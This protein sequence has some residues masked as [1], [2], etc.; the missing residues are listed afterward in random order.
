MPYI[1][2]NTCGVGVKNPYNSFLCAVKPKAHI[3]FAVPADCQAIYE[4]ICELALYEKAADEVDIDVQDLNGAIFGNK[5]ILEVLVAELDGKVEGAAMFFEKYSTW[6]GKG[7]HLEDLVVR[8]NLRGQGIGAALFEALMHISAERGYARMD[9]QVLDW[10]EPAI[11]FYKK[12][13]AEIL[14]EWLNGRFTREALFEWTN[15]K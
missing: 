2:A 12:Y 9:W 7:V 10:N 14:E 1:I 3:R 13:G 5:P 11:R 6:K 8:E 15:K 4:L